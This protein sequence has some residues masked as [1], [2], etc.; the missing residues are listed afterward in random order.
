MLMAAANV[1]GSSIARSPPG[2][3]TVSPAQTLSATADRDDARALNIAFSPAASSLATV[4]F[5]M[6]AR[7]LISRVGCQRGNRVVHG[8][9]KTICLSYKPVSRGA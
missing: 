9:W 5:Y 1:G 6:L 4:L 3:S 8:Q 7:M 2:S